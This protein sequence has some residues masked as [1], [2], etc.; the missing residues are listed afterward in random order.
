L[1]AASLPLGLRGRGIGFR[2]LQESIDTTSSTGKLVFPVFATLAEFERDI[3]RERTEAGLDA[4]R[5]AALALV[6]PVS[7]WT[8][9]RLTVNQKS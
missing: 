8:L 6:P 7:R 2:S 1:V 4:A 3:I 5:P 9:G